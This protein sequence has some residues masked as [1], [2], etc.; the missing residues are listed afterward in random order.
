MIHSPGKW[1]EHPPTPVYNPGKAGALPESQCHWSLMRSCQ[2]GGQHA[3]KPP[4]ISPE[5]SAHQEMELSPKEEQEV[6][7]K[8]QSQ[9]CSSALHPEYV[10]V[11]LWMLKPLQFCRIEY[12]GIFK[13][14]YFL[15]TQIISIH[16]GNIQ[17]FAFLCFIKCHR[18]RERWK[19]TKMNLQR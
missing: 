6:S 16:C 9:P 19:R 8:R 10:Q 12:L 1:S 5:H 14:C 18:P 7:S 13:Q 15:V 17:R 11:R 4:S 2:F 3:I